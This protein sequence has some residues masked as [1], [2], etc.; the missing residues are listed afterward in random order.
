MIVYQVNYYES[1]SRYGLYFAPDGSGKP[2]GKNPFFLG[3]KER[4]QE[5]PFMTLEKKVLRE[6]F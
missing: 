5:A 4:P 1:P 3:I 2:G 6:D